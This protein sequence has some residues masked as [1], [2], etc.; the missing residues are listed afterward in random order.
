MKTIAQAIKD[1]LGNSYSL[2]GSGLVG[3][4]IIERD[5]D[6]NDEF[7]AAIAKDKSFIGLRADCLYN[8]VSSPNISESDLSISLGDR[9]VILKMANQFYTSIGEEEKS[10]DQPKVYIGFKD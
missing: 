9:N 6:P 3:N 4:I 7:D 10:L 8:L 5:L 1:Y 2:L